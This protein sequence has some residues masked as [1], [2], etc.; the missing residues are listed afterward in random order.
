MAFVD[1]CG[2]I[3][4]YNREVRQY[5][6]IGRPLAELTRYCKTSTSGNSTLLSRGNHKTSGL[7]I[8]G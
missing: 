7:T 2:G 1:L 4:L 3:C 6:W 8:A 5:V